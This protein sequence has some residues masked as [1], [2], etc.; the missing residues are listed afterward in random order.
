MANIKV[1]NETPAGAVNGV[2]VTFTLAFTPDPT[3]SDAF[4]WNGLRLRRVGAAPGVLEYTIA[5]VTITL[6][7]APATGDTV[8]VDY[9][10]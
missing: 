7:T 1:V 2:N 8:L 3:A 5:G 6:G 4:Y 10:R 9:L